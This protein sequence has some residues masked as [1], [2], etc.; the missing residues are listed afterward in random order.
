MGEG[1]HPAREQ[2]TGRPHLA[3]LSSERPLK[4]YPQSLAGKS[5]K[6]DSRFGGGHSI[7]GL[8]IARLDG[9][10]QDS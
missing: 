10:S 1:K 8:L 2:G 7:V 6:V 9:Q 3:T 4:L 5:F